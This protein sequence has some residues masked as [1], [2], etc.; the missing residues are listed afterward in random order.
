MDRETDIALFVVP[1]TVLE[2][3]LAVQHVGKRPSRCGEL[4]I[5]TALGWFEFYRPHEIEIRIVEAEDLIRIPAL[6]DDGE[7]G[8]HFLGREENRIGLTRGIRI[9]HPDE[10]L[11]GRRTELEGQF[12]LRRAQGTRGGAGSLSDEIA[13]LSG[14][15]GPIQPI[16]ENILNFLRIM[17]AAGFLDGFDRYVH[18][19]EQICFPRSVVTDN[20]IDL[21]EIF[22]SDVS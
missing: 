1:F 3:H 8:E 20:D 7:E 15:E 11:F 18:C 21:S 6:L 2:H 12:A 5:I 9:L 14:L 19:L 16:R 10:L 13:D 17:P 22:P 4:F